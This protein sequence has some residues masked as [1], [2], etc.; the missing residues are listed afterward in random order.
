ME[1]KQA[2]SLSEKVN[3]ENRRP[4]LILAEQWLAH[5]LTSLA[6]TLSLAREVLSLTL[7]EV[8]VAESESGTRTK[9]ID[10]IKN[11]ISTVVDVTNEKKKKYVSARNARKAL[12]FGGQR[13]IPL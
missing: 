3:P 12:K 9:R 1:G 2:L 4:C 10:L 8:N 11:D 7:V 13:A 6:V 5:W